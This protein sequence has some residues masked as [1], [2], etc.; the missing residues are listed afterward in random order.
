MEH[1]VIFTDWEL[2][3]QSNEIECP[4]VMAIATVSKT[5]VPGFDFPPGCKVLVVFVHCTTV[6]KT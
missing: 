5:E 6:V 2:L 4:G 1:F 3:K